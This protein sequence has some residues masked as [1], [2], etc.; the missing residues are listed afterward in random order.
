MIGRVDPDRVAPELRG[1]LRYA[2]VPDSEHAIVRRAVRAAIALVP[3]SGVTWVTVERRPAARGLRIHRS[4]DPPSRAAMLFVHGG[5]FVIGRA[6][7]NDRLCGE[8]AAGLGIMVVAPEYRKAPEHPFPAALD[9]VHAAWSWLQDQ[10][11][12]LGLDPLRVV[13]GG[14]SAGGGI[15]AALAQR[16]HDEGGVQPAGQL[17]FC[18]MLDDRTAADRALDAVRHPV[19]DNRRNRFGW[20]SYLGIEPGAPS[21]PP[22]AVAARRADLAGLPPAWIGYG[23]I[24]LFRDEDAGYAARLRAAGVAV[25]EDVVPG[26][27]HGFETWAPDTELARRH[28]ARARD[29]LATLLT[30]PDAAG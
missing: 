9:D 27:A 6:K 14:E 21:V 29:W 20:R 16:L 1:R 22:Y 13:I 11:G 26:A 25:T 17:L 19:W 12:P 15:A 24:E 23:D 8:L 10:A 5:G 2:R 3:S 7:V 28:L 18:P 4:A 30:I